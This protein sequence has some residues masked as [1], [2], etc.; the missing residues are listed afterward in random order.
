MAGLEKGVDIATDRVRL[1]A[2]HN[3]NQNHNQNRNQNQSDQEG[4]SRVKSVPGHHRRRRRSTTSSPEN[5]KVGGKGGSGSRLQKYCVLEMIGEG[6]FGKVY[7]GRRRYTGQIVAL[8]FI[9]KRGKS[10]KDTRNLRS[11]IE[12]LRKLNHENII[13]MLDAFETRKEFVVVTEFAQGELF[14]ILEDD[15]RLPE[16]EVRKIARQLV[17]ALHYLHSHRIIHRDMKPQN[18]LISSDGRVKLCDFGFARAMSAQTAMVTSIKGTPLYMAPEL[19]QEQPYNHTADL[20]SLGVILYELFV[21]KPPFY[22]NNIYTLISLIMK[23]S[24][25]YPP[26][27]SPEFKSFL[28]GLLTKQASRRLS[29]PDLLHHPFVASKEMMEISADER[30]EKLASTTSRMCDPRYRMARF[31]SHEEEGGQDDVDK[32]ANSSLSTGHHHA[33]EPASSDGAVALPPSSSSAAAA[34][35]DAAADRPISLAEAL[36]N[37]SNVVAADDGSSAPSIVYATRLC[38][39]A[40]RDCS[41]AGPPPNDLSRAVP[42]LIP[43]LRYEHDA[44]L[45]VQA[46][47]L[48]C[49]GVILGHCGVYP[50][51]NSSVAVWEA[52]LNHGIPK[53][54]CRCM[55][56]NAF[57]AASSPASDASEVK[58]ARFAVH[59]IAL[60]LHPSGPLS[61][62]TLFPSSLGPLPTPGFLST[63]LG[64]AGRIRGETTDAF[65]DAGG[66]EPL[67]RMFCDKCSPRRPKASKRAEGR[68]RNA[69][70]AVEAANHAVRSAVLRVFLHICRASTEVC[71]V[72]ASHADGAIV[73]ICIALSQLQSTSGGRR[74]PLDSFVEGLSM[75]LLATLLSRRVL[76]P[77]QIRACTEAAA[78]ALRNAQDGRVLSAASV[79]Y[80]AVLRRAVDVVGTLEDAILSQ[81]TS[82]LPGLRRL[83]VSSLARSKKDEPK[84]IDGLQGNCFGV[85][86]VGVADSAVFLLERALVVAELRGESLY[87]QVA[88]KIV[89]ARI[90]E[91]LCAQLRIGG[92]GE[93]S[94][95][96]TCAAL[97]VLA[98]LVAG[99]WDRHGG[100]LLAP[101]M[102]RGDVARKGTADEDESSDSLLSISIDVVRFDHLERVQAWPQALS[103]GAEGVEELLIRTIGLVAL[104][105]SPR[106]TARDDQ[107]KLAQQA[108][109][110]GSFI[111][112]IIAA[113]VSCSSDSSSPTSASAPVIG[114]ISRLVLGSPHF[115]RQFV[116]H[117]GIPMIKSLGILA[118]E[119]PWMVL[120][121]VLLILSQL[122][123]VS[124]VYYPQLMQGKLLPELGAL[125]GHTNANARSKTCNMLGN[126]CRHSS[127]FYQ[128]LLE[129]GIVPLLIARCD[130]CDSDTRKFACFAVGNGSFHSDELYP[131]LRPVIPSLVQL[132]SDDDE[133]SRANAAGALG[134]LVR[135][136]GLLCADLAFH[137]APQRLLKVALTDPGIQPRRISLF[138]LGNFCAYEE[139]RSALMAADEKLGTTFEARMDDLARSCADATTRKYVSRILSKLK[140]GPVRVKVSMSR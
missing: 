118:L 40:L 99:S 108:I 90:F 52:I 20:W 9:S 31:L 124:D 65:V 8:K 53:L 28:Q 42:A 123:R 51:S 97:V 56:A 129:E 125:L 73:E 15:T 38:R 137:G 136:S 59:A 39:S 130:D 30:E 105:F 133:K 106:W 26:D 62:E 86:P 138:S 2:A 104:P 83:L 25:K 85:R 67:Q 127:Y 113:C 33:Q 4:F 21:G 95:K 5:A 132:L 11:E 71:A 131:A 3:R 36:T 6:S 88:E 41:K 119:T 134:N 54:L 84:A 43:L 48:K 103:G 44:Q 16:P 35:K 115:G 79:L 77:S 72:V 110:D 27:M 76:T 66:L 1:A 10:K 34:P 82:I 12:I 78:F 89:A 87:S 91:P 74:V 93:L 69:E 58:L 23:D 135:N 32:T 29:W 64:I 140:K 100:L 68:E 96:G 121:D 7:K 114:I 18:I 75:L 57:F 139:P 50:R 47:A 80:E 126:V 61:G 117:G 120:V 46:Q 24:V 14:Q 92:G 81:G 102:A 55:R 116:T 17:K 98:K 49:I 112:R 101:V 94:P 109:Y 107:V 22:T 63:R 70:D 45:V 60:L 122:A 37:L 13:L 19:V 128:A 111:K